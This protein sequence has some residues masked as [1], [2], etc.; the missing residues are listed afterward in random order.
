MFRLLAFIG[1]LSVCFAYAAA[2][3]CP[4]CIGVVACNTN[5]TIPKVT[6]T[7]AVVN[8][9][10]LQLNT[11]YRNTTEF[12]ASSKVYSC[13]K[14]NFRSTGSQVDT[15]AVQGC[16]AG[17]KSICRQPTI[18]FNGSLNCS[19]QTS[20]SSTNNYSQ[21]SS[22]SVLLSVLFIIGAFVTAS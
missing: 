10:V 5:Q 21:R 22:T 6:C 20:S 15:F 13:V 19:S 7:P 11:F 14:V 1:A 8:Q 4:L 12:T 3:N 18:D 2:A 17:S 9:T 16:T